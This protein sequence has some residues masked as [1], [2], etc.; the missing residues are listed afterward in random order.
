MLK[1]NH[2][3]ITVVG[4]GYVG[5]ITTLGLGKLGHRVIG[6]DNNEE[7]V[8]KL[9]SGDPVIYEHGAQEELTHLLST[10]VISFTT[11]LI[12]SVQASEVIFLCL[13]TPQNKEGYANL[14]YI[15]SVVSRLLHEIDDGKKRLIVLKST[16]PVKTNTTLTKLNEQL[17]GAFSF[18]SNPEFLRQG[19]ALADFLN[20]ERIVVGA[21]KAEDFAIMREVYEHFLGSCEYLEFDP[22]SAELIKYAANS[23]LAT[24]I[25][26]MNEI[27]AL[28]EEV[29]GDIFAIKKG[30]GSDKR[31]GS[32]FLDAGIGYGGS[33]FP[34]DVQALIAT[35][36]QYGIHL[37]ILD[38]AHE[39]NRH[40]KQRF[41]AKIR[42]FFS[43][44]DLPKKL[45]VLG[46]SFKAE[47]DDIRES[48]PLEIVQDLSANGFEIDAYDPQAMRHV[49]QL[50]I[51]GLRLKETA[52]EIITNHSYIALLTDWKNFVSEN[53]YS[54]FEQHTVMI[55]DARNAI[56]R[57]KI[58]GVSIIGVGKPDQIPA[59]QSQR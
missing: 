26:F 50:A 37:K 20:P 54:L 12:S 22:E 4:T 23:F 35:G 10:K 41:A 58:P 11:D 45:G 1:N 3:H 16:V 34:K 17:Q 9:Q 13:P 39:A 32:L 49:E 57:S 30:L 43:S 28:A 51:E 40:T 33:C 25:S 6:V 48:A 19:T 55:F 47:T 8:K 21:R 31:I 14:E 15:N 52:E 5:L 36:I 42:E 44:N 27:A 18:V 24:K 2:M 59:L 46:L 7:K 56:E 53:M 38:A 29:G